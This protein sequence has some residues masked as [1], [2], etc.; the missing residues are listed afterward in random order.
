M[1]WSYSNLVSKIRT[2]ISVSVKDFHILP[3][4][5][6]KLLHFHGKLNARIGLDINTELLKYNDNNREDILARW[7]FK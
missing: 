3:K 7:V 1:A 5:Q 2:E 6:S 4:V